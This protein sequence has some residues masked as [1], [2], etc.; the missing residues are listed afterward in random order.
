M[1]SWCVFVEQKP[2][3]AER[4]FARYDCTTVMKKILLTTAHLL[5]SPEGMELIDFLPTPSVLPSWISE[6]ELGV[7]ADKFQESGFTGP[8]NYYRAM[9]L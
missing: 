8:L 3:R 4:A 1:I 2:G 7:F 6:E 5:T 9:D